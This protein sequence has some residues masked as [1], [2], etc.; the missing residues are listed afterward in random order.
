MYEY[1]WAYYAALGRISVIEEILLDKGLVQCY[2]LLWLYFN[3]NMPGTV[4]FY[5]WSAPFTK[6]VSCLRDLR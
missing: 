4:P 2:T 5:Q 3:C 1:S 6:C